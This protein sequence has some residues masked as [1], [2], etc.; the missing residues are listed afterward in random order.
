[1]CLDG[2]SWGV[3]CILQVAIL[4]ITEVGG[5]I[6]RRLILMILLQPFSKCQADGGVVPALKCNVGLV[7][8]DALT[9]FV[10]HPLDKLEIILVFGPDHLLDL[11]R[12]VGTSM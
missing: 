9:E 12:V 2:Y 7:V 5:E 3:E 1:M 8:G 10:F 11:H 4:L 6:P